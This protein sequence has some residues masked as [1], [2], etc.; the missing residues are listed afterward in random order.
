MQRKTDYSKNKMM[1]DVHCTSKLQCTVSAQC[2]KTY[3]TG[4]LSMSVK[5]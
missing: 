1:H 5:L 3:T 4:H 2:W